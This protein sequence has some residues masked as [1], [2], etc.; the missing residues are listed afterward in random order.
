MKTLTKRQA[1]AM[2][3]HSKH[4]TKKHMDEMTRLMTRTRN[5]LNFTQAHKAT[6][7]KVGR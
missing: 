2:K 1:D 4:H 7:K 6:M 5:P 3:R